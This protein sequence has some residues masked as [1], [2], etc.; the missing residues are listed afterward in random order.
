M[1]FAVEETYNAIAEPKIIIACGACAVSGG[2]FA[3]SN[4]VDRG[5]FAA[6]RMDLYVPGCPPHPLTFINGVLKLLGR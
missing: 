2:I 3:G 1:A 5:F 4:A 6:H